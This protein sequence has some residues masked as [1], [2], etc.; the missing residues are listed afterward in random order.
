LIKYLLHWFLIEGVLTEWGIEDNTSAPWLAYIRIAQNVS[1]PYLSFFDKPEC[2]GQS[3][4]QYSML[5][6]YTEHDNCQGVAPTV[7]LESV[8]EQYPQRD[9]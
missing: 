3:E 6:G 5:V 8:E 7:A 2:T 9:V 1:T 4:P